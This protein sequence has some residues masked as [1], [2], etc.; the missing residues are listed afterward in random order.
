MCHRAS[1]ATGWR[2]GCGYEHVETLRTLLQAQYTSA[3]I[4]LLLSLALD[5]AAVIGVAFAALHGF[6]IFSALGF[7]ALIL[8]TGHTIRRV[9]VTRANLRQLAERHPPLPAAIV[10]RR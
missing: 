2:C 5:A 7:T 4:A 9:L 3:W 6:I 8:M 1:E 10:H